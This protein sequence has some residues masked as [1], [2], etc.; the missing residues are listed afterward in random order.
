[1]AGFM[2]C[3]ATAATAAATLFAAPPAAD[4]TA[5]G[6]ATDPS[7]EARLAGSNDRNGSMPSPAGVAVRPG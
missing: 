7:I 4:P 6:T 2:L 3:A 5:F 1:M